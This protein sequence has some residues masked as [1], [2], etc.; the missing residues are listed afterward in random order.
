MEYLLDTNICIYIIKRKPAIVFERLRK[1][2]FDSIA[3]SSI[4]VAELE[5]GVRKSFQPE[6]NNVALKDFLTPLTIVDFGYAATV[7]YGIIRS[8]LEIKGTPIGPMD[9][10]IAAHAKSLDLTLVTNN[11]SEFNRID[12]LRVENWTK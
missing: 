6:K 5:Y 12:G 9:L 4:S 1:I 3:I 10:L 8:R 7:E 2:A 11:E